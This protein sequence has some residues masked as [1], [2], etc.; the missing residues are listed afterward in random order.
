MACRSKPASTTK[1]RFV[2]PTNLMRGSINLEQVKGHSRLVHNTTH[3]EAQS[4][5][6]RR[7]LKKKQ[8]VVRNGEQGPITI[9]SPHAVVDCCGYT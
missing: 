8:S 3:Y 6:Q 7:E 2:R 1:R 4:T 9:A 5:V